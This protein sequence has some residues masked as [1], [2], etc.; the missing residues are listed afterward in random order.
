V[1]A[2]VQAEFNLDPFTTGL[3][4]FCNRK[5][6]KIKILQWDYNGFWLYYRR[7]EKGTFNWPAKGTSSTLTVDRRQ[8]Q[9]L[10]DGLT[11]EQKR[12]HKKVNADTVV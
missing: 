1:E 3:F 11:L 7:L 6:D 10:L 2:I 9:W 12:R 5:R 4:V 8:L